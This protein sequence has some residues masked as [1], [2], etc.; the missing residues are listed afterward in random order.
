MAKALEALQLCLKLLPQSSREELHR[1][2][3]FMSLAA[4]PRGLKV[5]Q[6]V[7][8]AGRTSPGK[9]PPLVKMAWRLQVE[10]RLAV[11]KS[12]SRAILN[13]KTLSKE[14]EDLLLVFMLSNV[15]EIFKVTS[16]N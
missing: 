10:N 13:S 7:R 14:R 6:E 4:D 8:S 2:L 1:L 15:K 9:S 3:T 5:D 12:F 16:R 11:K